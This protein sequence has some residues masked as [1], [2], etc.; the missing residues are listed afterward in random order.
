M[1][2][3]IIIRASHKTKQLQVQLALAAIQ[4][5]FAFV[6]LE[7]GFSRGHGEGEFGVIWGVANLLPI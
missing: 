7:L 2:G 3:H 5:H 4:R 1:K 6:R